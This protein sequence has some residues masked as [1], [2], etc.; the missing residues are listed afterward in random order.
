MIMKTNRKKGKRIARRILKVVGRQ[1]RKKGKKL[2]KRINKTLK[3]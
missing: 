2:T 1:S 3:K